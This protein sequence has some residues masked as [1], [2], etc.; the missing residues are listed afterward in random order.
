MD[1]LWHTLI[2]TTIIAISYYSGTYKGRQRGYPE[3][4]IRG[5][6]ATLENLNDDQ[7]ES[8]AKAVTNRKDLEK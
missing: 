1:P 8:I 4:Y 5:I 7:I 3:G 6:E 2:A